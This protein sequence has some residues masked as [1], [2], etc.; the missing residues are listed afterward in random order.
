MKLEL[1]S[2]WHVLDGTKLKVSR[3]YTEWLYL[4]LERAIVWGLVMACH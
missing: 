3:I 4:V 1:F 2:V